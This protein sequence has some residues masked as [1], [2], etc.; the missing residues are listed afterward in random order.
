M[1]RARCPPVQRRAHAGATPSRR[2]YLNKVG[3]FE[4]KGRI[5]IEQEEWK[6]AYKS[7]PARQSAGK[8][9]C[10]AYWQHIGV[11]S[12]LLWSGERRMADTA[13]ICRKVTMTRKYLQNTFF[14]L[15]FLFQYIKLCFLTLYEA[16]YL[17]VIYKVSRVQFKLNIFILKFTNYGLHMKHSSAVCS[18]IK[19]RHVLENYSC[20]VLN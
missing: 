15:H 5:R 19:M 12:V 14:P 17:A 16:A 2:F 8:G 18:S 11:L 7:S 10:D 4:D 1:W 6:N 3:I 9:R 13:T 20:I